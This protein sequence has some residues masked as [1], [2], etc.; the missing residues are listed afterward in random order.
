M[1]R[2]TMVAAVTAGALALP[3]SAGAHVSFH[4]NVVPVGAFATIA[5]RVPNEQDKADTTSV[6]IQ[7]PPG[8]LDV[9]ADPPPGWSFSVKTVRLATPVKTDDGTVTTQVSEV[10][11]TGGKISP[12]EFA[13][14]PMS[15]AMPGRAGAIL[16]FKT[17]QRYDDGQVAR[18]IDTSPGAASPAPTI[19][20]SAKGGPLLDVAGTEAG[21]P[22][23]AARTT[24]A[25]AGTAAPA[26]APAATSR[27]ASKGLAIAALIV[28]ILGLLAGGAALATRR[29][30]PA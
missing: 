16:T 8:F 17:V 28:G 3:A 30:A 14:F 23:S 19:A 27:G 7:M 1:H 25:P 26:S 11:F 6:A 2:R 20:V 10:D 21:P 24:A 18:W 22:A 4:P 15:V 12:G 5:L 29:G 9:S 13:L